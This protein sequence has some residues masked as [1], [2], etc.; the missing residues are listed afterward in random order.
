MAEPKEDERDEEWFKEVYGKEYTG[1]VMP[2]SDSARDNPSTKKRAMTDAINNE[3]EEDDAPPDPNAVPT[4]FTSREAKVWEAKAKAIERNWK[5][6]KE[7]ELIC[8]ICGEYGHFS[9]GCPSTLG[10]NRRQTE[11]VEKIPVK[12]RR[13]KPRIIGTGGSTVQGIEKDTGCRLKLEDNLTAGNGAFFVRISGSNRMMVGKA[14]DAVKRLLDHVQDDRKP[15]NARKSHGSHNRSSDSLTGAHMQHIASQQTQYDPNMQPYAGQDASY[16]DEQHNS[17]DQLGA[18][19]QWETGSQNGAFSMAPYGLKGGPQYDE[20]SLSKG[21]S[22]EDDHGRDGDA[23]F[24]QQGMPMTLEALEQK[25]VQETMQLTKDLNDAEDKENA[26]HRQAIREI[27]EQYQQKMA[28]LRAAQG[29]RRDEFL[30]HD[31]HFRQHQYQQ[32]QPQGGSKY[33]NYDLGGPLPSGF[34]NGP[35]EQPGYGGPGSGDR[36]DGPGDSYGSY[37]GG[38]YH[39]SSHSYRGSVYDSGMMHSGA[40]GYDAGPY[41]Y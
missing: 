22:K 7:E 40:Q 4:D 27:Q 26:R 21:V 20:R 39:S 2:G 31:A 5:K 8:R 24:D 18:R 23:S 14:V 16:Y 11:I 13:L 6:K 37:R 32:Y 33:Y 19:R 29:K 35:R 10:V 41:R 30:R 25:F 36:N 28:S 34:S 12:D 1:P 9:Q 3:P 17:M 15:Q 38:G